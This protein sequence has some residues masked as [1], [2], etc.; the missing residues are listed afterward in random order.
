MF[1]QP[2]FYQGMFCEL[3]GELVDSNHKALQALCNE[4]GIEIEDLT[5]EGGDDLYF[6]KDYLD[7]RSTCSISPMS[8]NTDSRPRTSRA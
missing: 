5:T 1:T 7:G 6:L 8:T 2:N 3:G 4:L